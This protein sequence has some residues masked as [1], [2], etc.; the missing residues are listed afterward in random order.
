V[1]RAKAVFEQLM[2]LEKRDLI[3]KIWDLRARVSDLE[4]QNIEMSWRDNPDRMGGQF[5]REETER[6]W[7]GWR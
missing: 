3:A 4:K 6:G 2:L 5:T 1:N 7:D